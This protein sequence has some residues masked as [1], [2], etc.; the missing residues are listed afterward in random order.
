MI[1]TEEFFLFLSFV[2]ELHVHTLIEQAAKYRDDDKPLHAIQLLRRV[3]TVQPA[4]EHAYVLLAQ[5]YEE[6]RQDEAAEAV[7][8]QGLRQHPKS[9]TFY[10][11]LGR[12]HLARLEFT[13]ALEYFLKI[14]H[15][16]TPHVHMSLGVAYRGIGNLLQAERELKLAAQA[17]PKLPKVFEAWG[18]VL[19]ELGRTKDALAVLRRAARLDQYSGSAHHLLADALAAESQWQAAYE[20]YLLAV[21]MN[22]DDEEAWFSIANALIHLDRLDEAKRYLER[23]LHLKPN[24]L[25]AASVYKSVSA[26]LDTP[27]GPHRPRPM[28][29]HNR[30]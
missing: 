9:E 12:F 24:D 14:R 8:L 18:E 6:A 2:N 25:M 11:V 5:I 21:D 30:N 19:L 10:F 28:A 27:E 22:P 17:D 1:E 16:H 3:L 23:Y 15:L 13:R 29:R 4:C 26:T 20:E 7:L